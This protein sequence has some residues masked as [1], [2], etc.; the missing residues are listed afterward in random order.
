MFLGSN[1]TPVQ[2]FFASVRVFPH[3][4]DNF[5]LVCLP[6]SRVGFIQ[7]E[8]KK[9]KQFGHVL[10]QQ[11]KSSST[12]PGKALRYLLVSYDSRCSVSPWSRWLNRFQL[13]HIRIIQRGY[14]DYNNVFLSRLTGYYKHDKVSSQITTA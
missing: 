13:I 5:R 1:S 2:I 4:Q 8:T 6:E 9:K 10:L 7:C 14:D 12:L 3:Q 11:F